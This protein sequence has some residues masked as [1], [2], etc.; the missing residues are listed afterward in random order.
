MIN[1]K[2]IRLSRLAMRFLFFRMRKL[3]PFEIQ[4]SLLNACNLRCLYCRCPEIKEVT[5]NTSQWTEIIQ[6]LAL[7][8]AARIKFQ[9]GEPTLRKDFRELTRVVQEAGVISSVTTNGQLFARKPELL[10]YLDEVVFSLDAKDPEKNDQQ[11]GVGVHANIMKSIDHA[12]A[13]GTR[14]YINMVVSRITLDQIEP[15]LNFCEHKGIGF[16]AQPVQTDWSYA[17]PQISNMVLSDQEI[18]EMHHRMAKWKR[19]GRPLMF[20]AETYERTARWPDFTQFQFYDN[21]QQS[22]CMA[23]RYYVHIEPNG[24][25][26]PCG[27]NV[28]KIDHKNILKDGL[29]AALTKARSHNCQ[30]CG[31]AYLNERKALFALKPFAIRQMLNRD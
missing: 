7:L 25:V 14:V 2:Y 28:H 13:R 19:A 11:R 12:L 21:S 16:H 8:G 6:N 4:A 5:M 10:D 23:G 22:N 27:L 31:M 24:D 9:G 30:D 15:L 26:Y 1:G 18:R 17:D 3:H 20:S 29:E